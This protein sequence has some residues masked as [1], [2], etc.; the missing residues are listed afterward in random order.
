MNLRTIIAYSST[1]D[2]D[3]REYIGA[4]VRSGGVSIYFPSSVLYS[5][6]QGEPK[7]AAAKIVKHIHQSIKSLT[8]QRLK[9]HVNIDVNV[10]TG[11][12]DGDG[13]QLENELSVL[14]EDINELE[15]KI[16]LKTYISG[17]PEISTN[18]SRWM[19]ESM[20]TVESFF[21]LQAGEP[22]A[23]FPKN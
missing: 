6:Q 21:D 7:L 14:I 19:D 5:S 23:S 13:N 22:D 17:N 12:L 3:V 20:S 9:C 15:V 2:N 10:D 16:H 11:D 4:T 18:F 8:G 1:R